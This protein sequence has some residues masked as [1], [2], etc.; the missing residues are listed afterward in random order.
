MVRD[1]DSFTLHTHF[2]TNKKLILLYHAPLEIILRGFRFV[3]FHFHVIHYL[4]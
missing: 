1:I 3:H 4:H 2:D